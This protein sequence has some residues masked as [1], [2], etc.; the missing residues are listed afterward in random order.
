[1]ATHSMLKQRRS[2]CNWSINGFSFVSV[3]ARSILNASPLAVVPY[4]P[5]GWMQQ[6]CESQYE[7]S[8][9]N[10]LV[11]DELS[12]GTY[13][14]AQCCWQ[15]PTLEIERQTYPK[16]YSGLEQDVLGNLGTVRTRR[17]RL[18]DVLKP[19]CSFFGRS[20]IRL[21]ADQVDATLAV[22]VMSKITRSSS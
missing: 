22:S 6:I 2:S 19:R 5:Y 18:P 8:M 7:M 20:L 3:D 4:S 16:R 21:V 13:A 11:P 10:L 9:L 15:G 12:P 1:M 17:G 14:P